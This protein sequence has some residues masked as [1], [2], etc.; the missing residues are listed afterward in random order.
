MPKQII[1]FSQKTKKKNCRVKKKAYLCSCFLAKQK[2]VN[3]VF[4]EQIYHSQPLELQRNNKIRN[5]NIIKVKND[6]KRIYR[7]FIDGV[8]P[9]VCDARTI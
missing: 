4:Q 5:R 8:L 6:E 9:A 2:A 1:F 7:F 3:S